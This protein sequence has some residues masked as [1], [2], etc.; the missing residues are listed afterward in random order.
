[1]TAGKAMMGALGLFAGGAVVGVLF[2]PA[3]GKDTRKK[4]VETTNEY[5]EDLKTKMDDLMETVNETM[6]LVKDEAD[7][8][9]RKMKR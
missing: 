4:I 2:A 7:K 3:K 9:T 6:D 5:A 8:L 1:M